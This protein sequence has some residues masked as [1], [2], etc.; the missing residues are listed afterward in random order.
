MYPVVVVL[1]V[2]KNRSLDST[3]CSFG[4]II[5]VSGDRRSQTEPMSF[6]PAPALA[7]KSQIDLETELPNADIHVTF[8]STL[9][10]GDG[11]MSAGSSKDSNEGYAA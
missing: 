5:D 8:D 2:E 11:G 7:S 10:P 1:L 6:A 9:E 3:F 4:T